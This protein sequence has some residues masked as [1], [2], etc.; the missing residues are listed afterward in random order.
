ML[1]FNVRPDEIVA[2]NEKDVAISILKND[3]TLITC[4]LSAGDNNP[5]VL[6]PSVSIRA[7]GFEFAVTNPVAGKGAITDPIS[8]EV[9]KDAEFCQ[10][11]PQLPRDTELTF[12]I[13]NEFFEVFSPVTQ[14]NFFVKCTTLGCS[15]NIGY[16]S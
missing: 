5:E 9:Q 6:A 11:V 4:G 15:S 8:K 2:F 14:S 16:S 12:K 10:T 1:E 7:N 13:G 3:S